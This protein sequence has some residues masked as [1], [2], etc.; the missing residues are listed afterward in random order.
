MRKEVS[1]CHNKRNS[2]PLNKCVKTFGSVCLADCFSLF[3]KVLHHILHHLKDRLLPFIMVS[4]V[5]SDLI[6]FTRQNIIRF[7]LI[8]TMKTALPLWWPRSLFF[9]RKIIP[10]NRKHTANECLRRTLNRLPLLSPNRSHTHILCTHTHR[11]TQRQSQIHEK[12]QIK[13]TVMKVCSPK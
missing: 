13:N 1:M 2:L 6:S 5:V 11:H 3:V 10:R 9:I 7:P 12:Y 4:C 8:E